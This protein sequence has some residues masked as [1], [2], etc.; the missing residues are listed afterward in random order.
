MIG[1]LTDERE[2][3]EADRLGGFATG[4]ASGIRA[5]RYHALLTAATH[6]PAGRI[7]LVAAAEA[8]L[9][10]DAQR[11]P[12]SLSSHRYAPDVV[13]PDG[14]RRLIR[15]THE[16]W[17]TWTY[18]VDEHR[19]VAHEV[20]CEPASGDVVL[21]WQLDG[22][23]TGVSLC[24]RLL[25]AGR[26]YHSL[27]RENADFRFDATAVGRGNVAWQPYDART[28]ATALTTGVYTHA[29]AW[30]RQFSYEKERRRGLD[31]IEDLASPGIFRFAVGDGAPTAAIVLRAG[32][33]PYGDAGG[34]ADNVRAIERTRRARFADP[35]RRAADAY[36][37]RR[38]DGLTVI[39]GYPWFTDW[40]RDTF[41]SVRG[42]CLTS[43]RVDDARRVLLAWADAV[44]DGM[45]PNRF[46]DGAEAP[47]YNSVDASLWFGVV[48]GELLATGTLPPADERRLLAAVGAI[49]HG[50]AGGTRF[51]IRADEDGLLAA[52]VPGMQLTW[53]DA[54]VGDQV[55]TPRIGKPVEI[56]ALWINAL[57]VAER[58]DP[59]FAALRERATASFRARFARDDGSLYDVVDA[60]HVRGRNDASFRPNQI[61]AAGGLPLAL[62]DGAA[63]RA[64][65]DQVEARLWTPLG[66]RTLAPDDPAYCPRYEGGVLDRDGAYHQGTVWPWLAGPFVDAWLRVRGSGAA[67][68]AEA[69]RRFV[70]PLSAQLNAA[71][72]GH[73]CEIADGEAPHAPR[74]APFQA[75]SLAELLRMR[76]LVGDA[77]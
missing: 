65:V 59:A 73:L 17:P 58:V 44:S 2:W 50:Y 55:I 42:L 31:H 43:G 10:A 57:A 1:P 16:P 47:E 75:W 66:L 24:V 68:R 41:I 76:H 51:G 3:L 69:R 45:L 34:I 40:G 62:I 11:E 18:R 60:D 63:A 48:V 27:Q 52:G 12:V 30:Y 72:L 53:M 49:A 20:V 25:L 32:R 39:A 13:H 64:L 6:P 9:E 7:V 26:D 56:Q 70:A 36:L 22:G 33:A 14:Y 4:A 61:F 37:V 67:A 71:G 54:K 46:T 5:R 77:A 29:P 28:A 15:F 23:G 21:T 74:G 8:W 19:T 38:G 35:M